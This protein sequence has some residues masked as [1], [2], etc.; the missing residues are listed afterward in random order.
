MAPIAVDDC[1]EMNLASTFVVTEGVIAE[2][3]HATHRRRDLVDRERHEGREDQIRGR[4]RL[5]RRTLAGV[6]IRK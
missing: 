1:C 2:V 6:L 4:A 5:T 3:W